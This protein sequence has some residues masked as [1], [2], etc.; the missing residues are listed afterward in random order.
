[1]AITIAPQKQDEY[2]SRALAAYYRS[3]NSI[4][5]SYTTITNFR[6][7]YYLYLGRREVTLAVYRIDNSGRLKRLKRWPR[8]SIP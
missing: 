7:R 4:D 1:M 8:R 6:D 5:P 2:R 3:G